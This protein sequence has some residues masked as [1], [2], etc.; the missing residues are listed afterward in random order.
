M[1]FVVAHDPQPDDRSPEAR[2]LRVAVEAARQSDLR[3]VPLPWPFPSPDDVLPDR[4]PGGLAA[5]CGPIPQRSEHYFRLERALAQRG[6]RL[7]NTATASE[8]A[9]R[10]EH[11]YKRLGELTART[12]VVRGRT[13]LTRPVWASRCS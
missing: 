10:M 5:Y 1:L 11:W 8:Q 9:T 3:V 12:V 6:A 7:V 13:S 4:L 2:R